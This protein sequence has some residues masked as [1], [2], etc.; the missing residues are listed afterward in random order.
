M[1]AFRNF[2][3]GFKTYLTAAAMVIA[4]VLA[5]IGGEIQIGGLVEAVLGALGL[6]ALR[7]GVTTEAKS[8]AG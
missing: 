2:L 8:N 4:A 3:S 5:F 7:A 1:E 6:A